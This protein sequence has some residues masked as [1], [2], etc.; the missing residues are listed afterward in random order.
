MESAA[1]LC[2]EAD[3]PTFVRNSFLKKE[4]AWKLKS[5]RRAA[6][7]AFEVQRI[8]QID[9]FQV[10][11]RA[12]WRQFQDEIRHGGE[13]NTR[14]LKFFTLRIQ[15][16]LAYAEALRHTRAVIEISE[17]HGI[18]ETNGAL[19]N[20]QLNVQ[21]SISKALHT[22]GEVQTQLAEKIVQLT[23]VMKREVLTKPLEEMTTTY[24]ERVATM[25]SEGDKLDA[26]LFLSQKNVAVAFSKFNELYDQMESKDESFAM[27]NAA[28][29][30]DLW[31][32]EMSYCVYVQKLQQCR[33]EYV[34]K[35]AS[36]F[37]QYKTMELWRASVIQ[38]ALDTYIRKQKLTYSEMAGAMSES[39][40]AV[41]RINPDR[42][43]LQ[44]VRR[45][46]KNY[47]AAA[48][49]ASDDKDARLFKMLP[50]PIASPLLV[51]CGFLK[52]QVNGSLFS[53]WKD[54]LCALTQDGCLHLLDLKE[55]T[56]RAILESTEAFLSAIA[57]N[58]QTIEVNC[59]SIC[60]TNCRIEIL[61]KSVTPNFEITE[62]TTPSG[63]LGSMLRVGISR[64]LTFQC[65]SQSDLIDWVVAA[66]QFISVGSSMINR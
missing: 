16:D 56:T 10:R 40:A 6:I 42:D 30:E 51:R 21:S 57:T 31:L 45:I 26:M 27:T 4:N 61:G 53:S 5:E 48:L 15:A 2:A 33:V 35:M 18:A 58:E 37:H 47:T 29:R 39:Q 13:E 52:N 22:A 9:R 65:P 64:T 54:V 17:S 23:T 50:S 41:Q 12:Y 63:L 1:T 38:T 55:N 7:R 66:K 24:K 60:L 49:S 34:T 43:L 19:V 36:L 8:A 59:Q 46:P 62:V 25:L 3:A 44:S 20:D 28:K 11:D 32:A 14:L